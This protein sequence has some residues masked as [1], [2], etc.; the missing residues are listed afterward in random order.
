MSKATGKTF[1]R[2]PLKEARI[3]KEILQGET[4][5][6]PAMKM[7]RMQAEAAFFKAIEKA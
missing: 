1:V 6:S 7:V 5:A 3:L 4:G 2:I